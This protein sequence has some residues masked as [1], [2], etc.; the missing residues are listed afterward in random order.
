MKI[1]SETKVINVLSSLETSHT[2]QTK[3][4]SLRLL[5]EQRHL[6]VRVLSLDKY[7]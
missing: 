3:W 6:V 4:N 5:G 1:P 7:F 2:C